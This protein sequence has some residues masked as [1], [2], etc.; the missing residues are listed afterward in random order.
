MFLNNLPGG[1]IGNILN[2]ALSAA[3][4]PCGCAGAAQGRVPPGAPLFLIM[5]ISSSTLLLKTL[6]MLI[7]TLLLILLLISLM[8]ILLLI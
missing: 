8:F 7:L 5:I 4:Y 6:L 1:I 2:T 3:G